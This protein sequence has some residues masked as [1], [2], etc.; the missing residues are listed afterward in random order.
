MS[1]AK[2]GWELFTDTVI[3]MISDKKEG[4]IFILWGNF[5]RS[6]KVLIDTSKHF[7]IE[8][9]HPSPL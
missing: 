9:A 6:K 5:A 4:V 2:I 3:K 8:S 1:H 7:I